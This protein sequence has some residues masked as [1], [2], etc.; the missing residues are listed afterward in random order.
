MGSVVAF[1]DETHAGY[2]S[3]L[4]SSAWLC[5]DRLEL[6][7]KQCGSKV[8]PDGWTQFL[9]RFTDPKL[10]LADRIRPQPAQPGGRL[11]WPKPESHGAVF[12]IGNGGQR[13]SHLQRLC[14]ERKP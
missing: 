7:A 12:R 8:H 1:G 4:L 5:G 9:N 2:C 10:G 14:P 11:V 6:Q 13:G 3:N